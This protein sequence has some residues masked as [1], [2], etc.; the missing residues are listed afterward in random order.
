MSYAG[1]D[2]LIVGLARTGL[3]SADFFLKRGARVTVNDVKPES[4]L[5][6]DAAKARALGASAVLGGHP[7]SLF[8]SADLIVASPGVPLALEPIRKAV[9]AGVPVVGDME[10]AFRE[11][12]GRICAIT[13]S[14]GKTTTTA[15]VGKILVDA[16][17]P[18]VVA[19]NIGTPLIGMLDHDSPETWFVCEMSSFQLETIDRF[20]PSVASILN[21]TPDHLDRYDSFDSYADA[22]RRV[23]RSQ[24]PADSLVLNGDD[25]LLR[26]EP[27]ASHIYYFSRRNSLGEGCF[28]DG[29]EVVLVRRGRRDVLMR[30]D[31]IPLKGSHNLEN[32]MA[33]AMMAD[34]A[35]APVE[36]V[37]HSIE[38]FQAVPHRLQFVETVRGVDF[39]NDSKA[40]NVDATLKALDSF[41]GN[42]LVI[43]GGKDKGVDYGPLAEPCRDKARLVIL[44]GAAADKIGA[45]LAGVCPMERAA[46]MEAAVELG[47]NRA[48]PGDTVL[49]APACASFDMFNNFEHRG[50]V[51]MQAVRELKARVG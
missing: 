41:S 9:R 7:E 40:T 28:L 13:G 21:L 27:A 35:G 14:N 45:A 32:V 33:A 49:L 48:A 2:V 46:S 5:K 20:R 19:G 30:A 17:F 34:L 12:R 51:F 11:M 18:T 39:F 36:S 25:P 22:K 42:L 43:L 15:L 26:K 47:F 23:Y 31:A 3:A 4:A 8:L 44:I 16:G 1:K 50:E 29:P 6:E 10:I 24:T 38:A 37:R